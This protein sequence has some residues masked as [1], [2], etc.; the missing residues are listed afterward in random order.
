MSDNTNPPVTTRQ[1]A[2]LTSSLQGASPGPSSF[3]DKSLQPNHQGQSTK[4]T[5]DREIG[6]S[7]FTNPTFDSSTLIEAFNNI[8]L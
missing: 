7:Q 1:R 5:K 6:T 3:D 4:P 8:A 2:A